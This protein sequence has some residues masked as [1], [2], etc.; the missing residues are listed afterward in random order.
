M[1]FE[2]NCFS[3][4]CYEEN[5]EKANLHSRQ[6]S[7]ITLIHETAFIFWMVI[8]LILHHLA[9]LQFFIDFTYLLP[10]VYSY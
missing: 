8:K 2:K 3:H 7:N 1:L 10:Y 4:W 6:I 9:G 5:I